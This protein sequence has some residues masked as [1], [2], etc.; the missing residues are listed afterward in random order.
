MANR[1]KQV[2]LVVGIDKRDNTTCYRVLVTRIEEVGPKQ[3]KWN[4]ERKM[5]DDRTIIGTM[6]K[7]LQWL[8]VKCADGKIKGSSGELSRFNKSA[9]NKPLVIIS[10]ITDE[11]DIT[12]G[13]RVADYNGNVATKSLKDMLAYGRSV[14]KNGGIP[15]QN[16]KF[17][18]NNGSKQAFYSAFPG[19]N[20]IEEVFVRNNNKNKHTEIRKVNTA[21]NAKSLNKLQDIYTKEQIKE[22]KSG[23]ANGVDIKV[24]ANPK[25]SAQQMHILR[26]GL[27]C[28]ANVRPVAFPEFK[29]DI[30][31][32]Y[33]ADLI[34]GL[35]IRNYLNPNYSL[36]QLA[37]VSTAYDLG[38]KIGSLA[39]PNLSAE[40]MEREK[41]RLAAETWKEEKVETDVSWK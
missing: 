27:E 20:F 15:V 16:A 30:M 4:F 7:G 31:G 17:N 5:I 2:A 33:V 22:L 32:Y 19:C 24:Y 14:S 35:D 10:K 13:Y 29:E 11:K 41:D 9:T 18:T 1:V 26:H 36:A 3:Y 28:G 40:D 39:D 8:N 38:L 37:C 21:E 25:L 23:K 34:N 6:Q 12:L